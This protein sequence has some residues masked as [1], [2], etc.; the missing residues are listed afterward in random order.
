MFYRIDSE[1]VRDIIEEEEDKT[2]E[3]VLDEDEEDKTEED[4]LEEE[5]GTEDDLLEEEAGGDCFVDSM[6]DSQISCTGEVGADDREK[7]EP[8]DGGQKRK[9]QGTQAA[10]GEDGE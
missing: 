5:V 6:C 10:Q 8:E 7:E 9:R 2:E 1:V 3:D 4:V